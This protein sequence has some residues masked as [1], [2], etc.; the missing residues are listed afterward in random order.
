MGT[1][2]FLHSASLRLP[3]LHDD[4]GDATALVISAVDA[5]G[6]AAALGGLD[7]GLDNARSGTARSAG[8]VDQVLAV[9]ACHVEFGMKEVLLRRVG[10]REGALLHYGL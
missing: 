2:H 7:D 6:L 4:A 3:H 9:G 1:R 10:F 5:L 8:A